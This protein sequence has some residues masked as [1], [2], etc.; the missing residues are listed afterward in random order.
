[1]NT[2]KLA[3]PKKFYVAGI[4]V[5][6]IMVPYEETS[7]YVA[8]IDYAAQTINLA[9]AV[10]KQESLEQAYL[11]NLLRYCLYAMSEH[12]LREDDKFTDSL[13]HLLHQALT[14][15]EE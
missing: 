11:Q 10:F 15:R 14:M 3:I 6:V 8:G 12:G 2:K 7:G 4:P 5:D 9:G 13:A 1:M